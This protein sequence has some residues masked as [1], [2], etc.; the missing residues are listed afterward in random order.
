MKHLKLWGQGALMFVAA[1]GAGTLATQLLPSEE[2]GR[3]NAAGDTYLLG[4]FKIQYPYADDRTGEPDTDRA[5]VSYV[6]RWS[7]SDYP[8]TANCFLELKDASGSVVGTLPFTLSSLSRV[9]EPTPFQSLKVSGP[10]TSA[11]GGCEPGL[12]EERAGYVFDQARVEQATNPETGKPIPDRA[13]VL[14]GVNWRGDSNPSARTCTATITLED[15]SVIDYGPFD[16]QL[17]DGS[18]LPIQVADHGPEEIRGG[19]VT[20]GPLAASP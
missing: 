1:L 20:C 5:G 18:T 16:V 17:N 10:P 12:Y 13:K 6:S 9:A 3:A 11:R 7:G 2:L 8:G 19:R 15:D 14:F 4:E